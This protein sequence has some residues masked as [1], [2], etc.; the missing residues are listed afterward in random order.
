VC[1]G[2]LQQNKS[3]QA[4]THAQQQHQQGV[5]GMG[6]R[7]V[8]GN[9]IPFYDHACHS[10]GLPKQLEQQQQSNVQ[11][12]GLTTAVRGPASASLL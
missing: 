8:H 3:M 6:M 5:L 11:R 9:R 10:A 7:S 1:H 12:R 2:A 4:R